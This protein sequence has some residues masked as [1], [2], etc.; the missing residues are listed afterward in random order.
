MKKVNIRIKRNMKRDKNHSPYTALTEKIQF[1][2]DGHYANCDPKSVKGHNN[3][4]LTNKGFQVVLF[5]H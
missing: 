5:N 3:S 2:F 4:K 1:H